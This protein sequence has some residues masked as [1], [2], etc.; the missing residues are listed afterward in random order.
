M[1][2]PPPIPHRTVKEVQAAERGLSPHYHPPRPDRRR[3]HGRA[4]VPAPGQPSR[5]QRFLAWLRR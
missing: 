4:Y 3:I 2:G 5:W 1:V